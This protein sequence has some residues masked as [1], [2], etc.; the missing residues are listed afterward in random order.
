MNGQRYDAVFVGG[1]HN[2]LVAAT[3]LARSGLRVLVL[4][5]RAELGGMAGWHEIHPG[6]RVPSLAHLAPTLDRRASRALDLDGSAAARADEPVRS[7]CLLPGGGALTIDPDPQTAASAIAAHSAADGAAWV[8][9]HTRMQR[10]VAALR[11]LIEGTPPRLDFS[12]RRQLMEFARL[13]WAV[14]RQGRA[15][16]RELLRIISM[17]IADLIDENFESEAI[18]G[19]LALDAVL[20]TDHGPRSPNTAFTWLHRQT[21]FGGA[22]MVARGG[23]ERIVETLVGAARKAGV[24]IRTEAPVARIVVEHGQAGGVELADGTRVDAGAVVAN[25]D[26]VTTLGDLVGADHLDADYLRD[27]RA[28]RRRATTGKVNLALD[29]LPELPQAAAGGAARWVLA[30]S[31]DAVEGAFDQVKYGEDVDEP[32]LEITIPSLTERDCAPEG[33]HVMSVNVAYVPSREGAA[34]GLRERVIR[35]IE[36]HAPGFSQ[37]VIAGEAWGPV[38]IEARFGAR[39][40]HWHH[41]DIALD[42]FFLTRPVPGFNQYRTPID[43]LYLCGAGAHPGGGVTGI[44]GSNAAREILQDRKSRRKTA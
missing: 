10:H 11:P 37:S 33:Q 40:G 24:D 31:L 19:L 39:G 27:I 36:A 9:F 1:G 32:A 38:E 13:G 28:I 7:H 41:G 29:R 44:N 5:A 30:P 12:E 8:E 34:Q 35:C 21:L 42:Q 22:P 16:M 2:G 23:G 20:G 14:R 18:G 3:W 26:P 43:G 15:S 25:S 17:N 6:F 4:E